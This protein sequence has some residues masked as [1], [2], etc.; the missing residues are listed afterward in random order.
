MGR[1]PRACMKILITDNETEELSENPSNWCSIV[2][3]YPWETAVRLCKYVC[4]SILPEKT[5]YQ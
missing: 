5:T 3:A 4:V 2:S 1:D